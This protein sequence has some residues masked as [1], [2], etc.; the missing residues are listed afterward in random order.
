MWITLSKKK[1]SAPRCNWG[2]NRGNMLCYSL[3]LLS[4]CCIN[5]RGDFFSVCSNLCNNIKSVSWSVCVKWLP[6]NYFY[7]GFAKWYVRIA[8]NQHVT[9]R[10][11]KLLQLM[12]TRSRSGTLKSSVVKSLRSRTGKKNKAGNVIEGSE[13]AASV[14]LVQS[15]SRRSE[16]PGNRKKIPGWGRELE[17]VLY[18]QR[19]MR[20]WELWLRLSLDRWSVWVI[21]H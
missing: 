10:P 20:A 19:R 2:V 8:F 21:S 16:E 14:V 7:I 11:E 3:C 13:M 1:S 9:V 17:P 18:L 12:W 4:L 15:Q 5:N 6:F